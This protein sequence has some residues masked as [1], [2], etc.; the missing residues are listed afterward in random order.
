MARL[1]AEEGEAGDVEGIDP[2][3]VAFDH[4]NRIEAETPLRDVV[5]NP[6]SDCRF[7]KR[8]GGQLLPT[9]W[10][11]E[12]FTHDVTWTRGQDDGVE[13][14]QKRGAAEPCL[15]NRR[16]IGPVTHGRAPRGP[17]ALSGHAGHRTVRGQEASVD[18]L[19]SKG[20]RPA[21]DGRP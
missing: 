13:G 2:G 16:S 7:V 3:L 15:R 10:D 1:D 20:S 8:T 14:Q 6:P 12:E 21:R 18:H 5:R 11:L 4:G 19:A 9:F 17:A